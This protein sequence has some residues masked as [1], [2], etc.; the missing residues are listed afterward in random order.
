MTYKL[1]VLQERSL[2]GEVPAAYD[3]VIEDIAMPIACLLDDLER[4]GVQCVARI[5]GPF[6]V[7]RAGKTEQVCFLVNSEPEVPNL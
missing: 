5:I 6:A 7:E 4:E 2:T 1:S 3:P